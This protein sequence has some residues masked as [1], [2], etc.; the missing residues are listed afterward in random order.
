MPPARCSTRNA[1][2]V[3][4][5]AGTHAM[6]VESYSALSA[7][8]NVDSAATS[9]VTGCSARRTGSYTTLA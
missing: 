8:T 2:T 3:S 5:R 7:T 9:T 1:R 6:A 4:K